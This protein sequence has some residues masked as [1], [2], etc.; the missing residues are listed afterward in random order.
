MLSNVLVLPDSTKDLVE[1]LIKAHV[2]ANWQHGG[3]V[4]GKK[5]DLISGKERGLIMLLHSSPGTGKTLI[6][7][8][9]SS[10]AVKSNTVLT[11]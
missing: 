6:A 3:F 2:S 4:S 5:L 11:V 8:E 9:S 10:I 7:G 1:A